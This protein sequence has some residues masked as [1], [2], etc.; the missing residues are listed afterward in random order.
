MIFESAPK[1]LDTLK[2]A[3][4]ERAKTEVFKNAVILIQVPYRLQNSRFFF[5]KSVKKSV[6][7]DVKSLT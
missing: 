7:R 6:K 3:D 2:M 1:W 4:C 5:S